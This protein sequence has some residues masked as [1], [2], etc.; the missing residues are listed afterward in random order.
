L[1]IVHPRANPT[2][3]AYSTAFLFITGSTRQSEHLLIHLRVRLAAE[4]VNRWR[5]REPGEHF[6]CLTV[7]VEMWSWT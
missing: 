7:A 1:A 3:I 5:A 6:A 4:T 2:L